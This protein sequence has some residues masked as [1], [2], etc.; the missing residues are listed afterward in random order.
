MVNKRHG[1]NLS[2]NPIILLV[3]FWK[4]NKL[5]VIKQITQVI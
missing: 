3:I 2:I 5:Q 1:I 4:L